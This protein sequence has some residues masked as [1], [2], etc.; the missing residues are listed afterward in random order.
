MRPQRKW[1]GYDVAPAGE[2]LIN[3]HLEVV[4]ITFFS[5]CLSVADNFT[6]L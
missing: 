1:P 4:A 2:D 6:Q 3:G 5:C